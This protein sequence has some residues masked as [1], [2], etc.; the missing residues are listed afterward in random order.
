MKRFGFPKL[1]G[2]VFL[3]ALSLRLWQLGE[4][5]V[6]FH[7]DEVRAGWNAYSILK[8]G[9]DDRGN[10]FAL[11]YDTFGDY[12]PTGIFY[13]TIP[14]V[15]IFGNNEF[16]VRFPSALLGALTVFPLYLFVLEIFKRKTTQNSVQ[17]H[18]IPLLAVLLLSVS[19]WHINVSRATSEVVISLFLALSGLYFFLRFINE[20]RKKSLYFGFL[21]LISSYF[22]YHSVRILVPLFVGVILVYYWKNLKWEQKRFAI[23][24]FVILSLATFLFALNPQARGRFAQVSIANDLDVRYELAKM[25]FEEGPNNVFVARLFHNK[26]SVYARRFVKEYSRYF[27]P[28]FLIGGLASPA[29]YTTVG[30]GLLTYIEFFLFIAGLIAIA[31]KKV[32]ILPLFLLLVAPLPAALTTEDAPNLHRSFFMLPFLSIIASYGFLWL[33]K[34]KRWGLVISRVAFLLFLVNIIFYLHMYYVH[35][36]VHAPLYR[37]V[38]AKELALLLNQTQGKYDKIIVTNIPDDPYPW[39]AF[40]GNRDP[41]VFNKDAVTREKGTWQ[42]ENFV[43]TGLRCPSRDAFKNPDVA[44]LLV[45]DADGCREASDLTGRDDIQMD[46]IFRPDGT[47]AYTLWSFK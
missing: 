11:Y 1:L 37:N 4:I 43:F 24:G 30:M 19:L 31:Q 32:I 21:F 36:K 33:F 10:R 8:T 20:G 3:L 47:E 9:Y 16:A 2:L 38:G 40:F 44:R 23:G 27:S 29:R 35:D 5:P 14:S 45:V 39:I 22:F 46:Q 42:T 18:A 7:A 26:P 12:R 6:G 13:V 25:P 34:I 15:A 41:A 17:N 28:D